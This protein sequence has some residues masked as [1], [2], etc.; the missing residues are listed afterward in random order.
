MRVTNSKLGQGSNSQ[1]AIIEAGMRLM[2]EVGGG[3]FSIRGVS[4]LSGLSAPTIYHHFGDKSGLL[5]ALLE[6]QFKPLLV[7]LQSIERHE[8]PVDDLR[9]RLR[10][11]IRF[12]LEHPDYYKLLALRVG[13]EQ[14]PLPVLEEAYGMIEGPLLELQKFGRIPVGDPHAIVQSLWALAHGIITLDQLHP[15]A[16]WSNDVIEVALNCIFYGAVRPTQ[17]SAEHPS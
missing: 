15:S 12:G 3:G 16:D 6:Q 5:D 2:E 4:R 17:R 10:L 8:D 14:H 11:F 13:D 7:Q 9:D 1:R